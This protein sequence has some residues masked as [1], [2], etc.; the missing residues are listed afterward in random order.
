MEAPSSGRRVSDKPNQTQ[1]KHTRLIV[2]HKRHGSMY[3]FVSI[4]GTPAIVTAASPPIRLFDRV[5]T[6]APRDRGKR[7]APDET[8]VKVMCGSIVYAR[9]DPDDIAWTLNV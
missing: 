1:A 9:S 8:N 4:R 5:V 3:G 2:A 6:V 7:D